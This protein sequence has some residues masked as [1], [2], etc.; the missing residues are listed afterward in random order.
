M[1]EGELKDLKEQVSEDIKNGNEYSEACKRLDEHNQSFYRPY[2]NV[3]EQHFKK[4]WSFNV[5]F[6][7][8]RRG[9]SEK[10]QKRL[11]RDVFLHSCISVTLLV[12]SCAPSEIFGNYN[13]RLMVFV[14]GIS[15]AFAFHQVCNWVLNRGREKLEAEEEARAAIRSRL[16]AILKSP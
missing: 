15:F 11:I 5:I 3:T 12:G 2:D 16:N 14:S 9:K 6:D 7:N 10:M 13:I 8:S 1:T 4:E